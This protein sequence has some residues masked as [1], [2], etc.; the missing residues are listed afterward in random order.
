MELKI[1]TMIMTMQ[2]DEHHS[3]TSY[4]DG[5]FVINY[6]TVSSGGNSVVGH[7]MLLEI[8]VGVIN[9]VKCLHITGTLL[10]ITLCSFLIL[11]EV[12]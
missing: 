1:F 3:G 8:I 10:K 5:A 6:P 2:K 12:F 4:G 9:M 11:S 7:L